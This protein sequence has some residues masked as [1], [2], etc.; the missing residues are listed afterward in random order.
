MV[1]DCDLGGKLGLSFYV[2]QPSRVFQVPTS[3]TLCNYLLH[4]FSLLFHSSVH[5]FSDFPASMDLRYI[6]T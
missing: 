4:Y 2:I 3:F 1:L 5:S 6:F